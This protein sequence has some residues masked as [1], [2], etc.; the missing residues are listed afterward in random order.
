[1]F[2]AMRPQILFP[3]FAEVS[4]LKG[5]GPKILPLVQKLAGPL[6]RAALGGQPLPCG[7]QAEIAHGSAAHFPV[8]A[9]DLMPALSGAAL[10]ARMKELEE[11]W[12]ASGLRLSREQLLA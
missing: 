5:V 11:R 3:L 2:T 1:M 12:L 7:W 4:S 9:R 6:V 10:G 8:R